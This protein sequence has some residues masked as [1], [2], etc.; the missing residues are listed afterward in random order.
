MKS[1]SAGRDR[2]CCLFAYLALNAADTLVA[3]ERTLKIEV[4]LRVWKGNTTTDNIPFRAA[5]PFN[6]RFG[7]DFPLALFSHG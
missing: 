3:W 1:E 5:S 4:C 6:F 2:S 7:T